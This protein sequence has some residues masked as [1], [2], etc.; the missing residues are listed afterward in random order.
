MLNATIWE[1]ATHTRNVATRCQT[2]L[3]VPFVGPL[4]D[5]NLCLWDVVLLSNKLGDED[6]LDLTFLQNRVR[7]VHDIASY[8]VFSSDTFGL[9]Q[10][11][12][13]EI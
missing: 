13:R 3:A 12:A 11:Q 8:L 1:G 10:S 9:I 4:G 7:S 2:Q 6:P 5:K